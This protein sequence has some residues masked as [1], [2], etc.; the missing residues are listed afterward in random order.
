VQCSSHVIVA[1][2]QRRVRNIRCRHLQT[3]K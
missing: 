2:M 1:V 3:A